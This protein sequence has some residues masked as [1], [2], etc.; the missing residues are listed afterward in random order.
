MTIF[1][2]NISDD[3]NLEIYKKKVKRGTKGPYKISPYS[4]MPFPMLKY[5]MD[6]QNNNFFTMD[7]VDCIRQPAMVIPT[8]V[9]HKEYIETDKLKRSKIEF[10]NIPFEFLCRDKW[11]DI[12]K[13]GDKACADTTIDIMRYENL[14]IQQKKIMS[15]SLRDLVRVQEASSSD[16]ED[17][18][19]R[20]DIS[21]EDYSDD[22]E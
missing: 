9:N 19:I 20:G 22:D 21:E 12:N 6:N 2:S 16:E 13:Q 3:E 10:F 4:F 7:M 15:R 8:G 18:N 17:E 1:Y 5:K 14:T 11:E